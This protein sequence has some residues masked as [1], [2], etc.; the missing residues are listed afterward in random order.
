MKLT[1]HAKTKLKI[2]G[3]PENEIMAA[4]KNTVNEFFDE[5]EETYIKII[6]W[7]NN[8]FAVVC[9]AMKEKIITVYK[10]D[11]QIIINRQKNKRWT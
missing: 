7:Q 1:Q 4:L 11:E 2:Y 3:V 10:T 6:Q 5:K 8:L 9:D